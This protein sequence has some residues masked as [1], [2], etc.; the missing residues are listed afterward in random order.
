MNEAVQRFPRAI[1]YRLLVPLMAHGLLVQTLT[2]I[3]RVTTSYRVLDLGLPVIWLGAI[4]ATFALLPVF[5]AVWVG[6]FIDRGHDARAARLGSALVLASGV[7]LY[8]LNSEAIWILACTVVLGIGHLFLMASHQMLCVRA[9]GDRNRDAVFGNFLVTNG[10]GQGLGP[11]VVGWVGGEATIP[12][13]GLLF[14]LGALCCAVSMGVSMLLPA[15]PATGID[16]AG[17]PA[18]PLGELLRIPGFL[19]ILVASVVTI[20]AQ[21]LVTIYLPLLGA[22]RGIDSGHIGLVLTVRSGAA[23]VSR[24]FYAMLIAA[25]GRAPLTVQSMV[26]SG[27]AFAALALP[28]PLFPM[29]A[30]AVLMGLGL[31]VAT[32]LSLTS[33]VDIVPV[34]ARATALSLRITGNRIGQVS[35]PFVASLIASA[36]GAP[37]VLFVIGA[38]LCASAV[39]VGASARRRRSI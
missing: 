9:A 13:T 18:K 4:S 8:L 27:L 26:L 17:K 10:I 32:T 33:V 3:L 29:Y 30:D 20:T 19:T 36:T 7:G 1:D 35:L 5:L 38:S 24:L 37:G 31:G 16:N 12:D 25:I 14:G 23:I 11:L 2:G 22:E 28:L 34:D 15:A 39:S 6:R 21:D